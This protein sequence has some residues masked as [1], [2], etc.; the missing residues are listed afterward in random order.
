MVAYYASLDADAKTSYDIWALELEREER[1]RVF[2]RHPYVFVRGGVHTALP[3]SWS[4][5]I[6]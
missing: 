5:S 3:Q 2:R 4:T 6:G 1:S